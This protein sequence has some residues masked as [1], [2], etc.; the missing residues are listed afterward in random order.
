LVFLLEKKPFTKHTL[1]VY[2]NKLFFT[3]QERISVK[4]NIILKKSSNLK[5]KINN[6]LVYPNLDSKFSPSLSIKYS[7]FMMKRN[8]KNFHSS[9]EMNGYLK[10][11]S[12]NT[13]NSN[14]KCS[15]NDKNIIHHTLQKYL[16]KPVK[17][18]DC[19]SDVEER[20]ETRKIKIFAS[21]TNDL[22]EI[23]SSSTLNTIYNN[24]NSLEDLNSSSLKK[25]F[26]ED[27]TL[28]DEGSCFSEFLEEK[29]LE[30][31]YV[32]FEGYLYKLTI[33]MKFK[34]IWFKLVE[35]DLFYYKTATCR[36]HRG[37]Q[38]LSG[39]FI[40]KEH[41]LQLQGRL[42]FCFSIIYQN[43]SRFYY[44]ETE[45]EYEQWFFKL[46]NVLRQKDVN[47]KYKI[48]VS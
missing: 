31:N 48:T 42:Y 36:T 14:K 4:N 40:N 47:K 18:E 28:T 38:N 8:L 23:E 29:D 21:K 46:T 37:L 44:V 2:E 34:K 17:E 30:K 43:K 1:A 45:S 33:N 3:E 11:N 6:F 35:N 16:A 41:P 15:K 9:R 32:K 25:Y 27:K 13:I 19:S 10:F 5:F 39:S 24:E 22:K 12:N 20:A 7:P 26:N